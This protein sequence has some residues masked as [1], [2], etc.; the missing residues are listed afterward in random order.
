M[1]KNMRVFV[2]GVWDMSLKSVRSKKTPTQQPT[3]VIGA[4]GVMVGGRL[5]PSVFNGRAEAHALAV[6][7]GSGA[8]ATYLSIKPAL[9]YEESLH[10]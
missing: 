9:S 3:V 10:E 8:V 4:W 1:N 2:P 6:R 5:V 7:L